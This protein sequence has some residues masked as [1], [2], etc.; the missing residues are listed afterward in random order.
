L[1]PKP[2]SK[3]PAFFNLSQKHS[4]MI[5]TQTIGIWPDYEL[6]DTGEFEKL[7]RFGSYI[8]IRPEPQAIWPKSDLKLWQQADAS[9]KRNSGQD[10][11]KGLWTRKPNMPD[12]WTIRYTLGGKELVFRLAMT[13]FKHLGIFPEQAANWHF[14]HDKTKLLASCKVLNLFAY[15]GGATLAAKAAGADVVHLDS[16]RVVVNW[17]SEN[18]SLSGLEGSRWVVEDALKFV[19]RQVKKGVVYQGIILDPPAYGRGPEGEK[20]MLEDQL[21]E[22]LELCAQLLDRQNRFFVLNLY[23]MGFSA[24]IGQTL[25]KEHFGVEAECGELYLSDR[26]LRKLPLGVYVR[27]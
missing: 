8:L 11:E 21:N 19:R 25:V 12:R 14:I 13:S 18:Q 26:N 27:F 1:T 2:G 7:E 17:A 24:L 3:R 10:A 22:M 16:V 9:F 15:T 20:W 5:Q 23:S 4:T 6:I